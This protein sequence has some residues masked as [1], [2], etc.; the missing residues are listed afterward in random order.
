M[1]DEDSTKPS[2]TADNNS[3]QANTAGQATADQTPVV[4]KEQILA[5]LEE[6]KMAVAQMKPY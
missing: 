1:A 5:M 6:L 2:T 4:N 3:G